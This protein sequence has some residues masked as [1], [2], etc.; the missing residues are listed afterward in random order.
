MLEKITRI[1]S[2]SLWGGR[3]EMRRKEQRT[4]SVNK[5]L[6]ALRNFTNFVHVLLRK[7]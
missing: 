7:R 1:E 3:L 6:A 2:V 4:I 5:S